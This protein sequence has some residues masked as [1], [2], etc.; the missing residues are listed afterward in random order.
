MFLRFLSA[1]ALL[2]LLVP[3]AQAASPDRGP[4]I[5]AAAS[6]QEAMTAAADAWGRRGHARPVL[7]FAGS[8]A[9]SLPSGLARR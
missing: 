7:S 8:S 2:L 9:L 4:L 3:T 6:M 5:L 1:I